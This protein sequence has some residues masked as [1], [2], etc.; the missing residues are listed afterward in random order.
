ML[1]FIASQIVCTEVTF[2][3]EGISYILPVHIMDNRAGIG[4]SQATYQT[5]ITVNT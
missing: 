3:M 2:L 1:F 5:L 4:D